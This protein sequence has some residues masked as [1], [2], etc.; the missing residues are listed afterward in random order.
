MAY[1]RTPSLKAAITG[2]D[3][4]NPARF[5]NRSEIETTPLGE[6]SFWLRGNERVSWEMFKS[7][8]PWLRESDRVIVEIACSIRGGMIDGRLVGY[9]A[10]TL[11]KQCLVKWAQPRLTDRRSWFK[12]SLRVTPPTAS[13]TDPQLPRRRL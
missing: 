4:V 2:A 3:K 6:P 7:E 11:L 13:L 5:T 8:L 12:V 9:Q 1:P 10:L